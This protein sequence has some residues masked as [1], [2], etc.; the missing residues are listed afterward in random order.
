MLLDRKFLLLP[1]IKLLT[2]KCQ[3]DLNLMRLLR[4]TDFGSDKN[5]L[6]LLYKSLIRPKLDYGAIVYS[7]ASTSALKMLDNI[8]RK[9]LAIALR[10]L[11]STPSVYLEL[12]AGGEPLTLPR[13]AQ[14][15]YWAR[16]SSRPCNPVNAIVGKGFFAK[17]VFKKPALPFGAT[18]VNLVEEHLPDV[19]GTADCRSRFAAPWLLAPPKV[20]MSLSSKLTKSDPPSHILA[21]TEDQIDSNYAEHLKIYIDESKNEN[22]AVSV[23]MVIPDLK[24]KITKRL[25]NRLSIYAAELTDCNTICIELDTGQQTT[26]S[27]Y[28]IGFS[29]GITITFLKE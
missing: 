24:V 25:S 14:V 22:L 5:S 18:M 15:K 20:D 27:C 26:Q 10:A 6:L 1:H 28:S 4:G 9:A 17:S 19:S 3:R 8:Q 12:E 13:E 23:A 16:I 21:I 29:F 2:E 7:C 11:P